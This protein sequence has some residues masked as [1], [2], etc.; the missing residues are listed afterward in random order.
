MRRKR[1]L[2]IQCVCVCL[3]NNNCNGTINKENIEKCVCMRKE[4]FSPID[5]LSLSSAYSACICSIYTAIPIHYVDRCQINFAV[6][7]SS[8]SPN[9]S[10][11]L[12]CVPFS[13]S[14][15]R[16]RERERQQQ[17]P[18]EGHTFGWERLPSPGHWYVWNYGGSGGVQV[19]RVN[20]THKHN[21]MWLIFCAHS[22]THPLTL[23]SLFRVCLCYCAVWH[24]HT[25]CLCF[26]QNANK[27]R[28]TSFSLLRLSSQRE[29]ARAHFMHGNCTHL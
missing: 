24:T 3:S 16:E 27:N 15:F 7:S 6:H 13:L 29:R 28:R 1:N 9:D 5:L 23:T 12:L 10:T 4:H 8:Y 18:R 25:Q 11:L 19:Y 20:S 26:S 17:L 22:L 2:M 14:G 21:V